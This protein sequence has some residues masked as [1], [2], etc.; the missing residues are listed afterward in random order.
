MSISEERI[1]DAVTR[2][3]R[4]KYRAGLSREG[5]ALRHDRWQIVA[6]LLVRPSIARLRVR[7][8]V[9]RWYC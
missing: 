7:Q 6:E 4:L 3:L 2:I 9:S 1:D 5:T 8:S